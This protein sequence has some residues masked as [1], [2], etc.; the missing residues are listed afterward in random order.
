VRESTGEAD[1]VEVRQLAAVL[2]DFPRQERPPAPPTWSGNSG[3]VLAMCPYQIGTSRRTLAES[4]PVCSECHQP[5]TA[6][7][8]DD[9]V[10]E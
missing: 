9:A 6:A 2:A 4:G 8:R 10:S 1:E 3:K 5:Y 7:D